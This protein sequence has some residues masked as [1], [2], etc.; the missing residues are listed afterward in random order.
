[1]KDY[2]S[3]P[4]CDYQHGCTCEEGSSQSSKLIERTP[5]RGLGTVAI[6]ATEFATPKVPPCSFAG[7]NS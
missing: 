2:A 4:K 6:L 5:I 7:G 1:M 3:K